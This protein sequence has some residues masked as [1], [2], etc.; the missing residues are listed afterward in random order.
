MLDKQF[1]AINTKNK[2]AAVVFS[3][4]VYQ[5][6]QHRYSIAGH[7]VHWEPNMEITSEMWQDLK[8]NLEDHATEWMV[9]EDQPLASSNSFLQEKRITSIVFNPCGNI[10]KNGDFLT[11]M[12]DNLNELEKVFN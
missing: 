8:Q 12:K 10:P 5:Y 9:W 4:P 3:H 11:V 2:H 6:L 1:L 7:S